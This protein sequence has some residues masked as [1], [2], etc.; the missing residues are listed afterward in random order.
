MSSR[1]ELHL[2]RTLVL[3]FGLAVVGGCF[4]ATSYQL[5]DT[6]PKGGTDLG[7][8]FS[9][10]TFPKIH[11]KGEDGQTSSV[12]SEEVNGTIPNPLPDILMRFGLGDNLDLGFKLFF[13]GIGGDVKWRFL[14]TEIFSM[15]IAPQVYYARPFIIFGQYGLSLPV[16]FT[17]KIGEMVKI[18]GNFRGELSGWNLEV[19]AQS[20]T[21]EIED[22]ISTLGIGATLGVSLGGKNWY[23]R[24]EVNYVRALIGLTDNCREEVALSY[25]TFGFGFGFLFGIE[26]EKQDRRIEELEERLKKLEQG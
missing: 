17:F 8:G 21:D 3:I 25:F 16:I 15:A 12:D 20:A 23:V 6:V 11:Y 9:A 18:Y 26:D 22:D 1:R 24:P 4:S 10:S 2:V 7:F 5:A 13:L 14:K 19:V